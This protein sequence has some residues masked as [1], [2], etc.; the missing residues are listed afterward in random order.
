ME[1]LDIDTSAHKEALLLTRIYAFLLKQARKRD[2]LKNSK[3]VNNLSDNN[4]M[5]ASIPEQGNANDH[6]RVAKRDMLN[7]PVHGIIASGGYAHG[8]M[9]HNQ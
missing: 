1:K 7:N 9:D 4:A 6:S 8:G 3:R 2:L 5:T